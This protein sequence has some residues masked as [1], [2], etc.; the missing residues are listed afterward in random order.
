M[1]GVVAHILPVSIT[2]AVELNLR[3]KF[4]TL[5]ASQVVGHHPEFMRQMKMR[6]GHCGCTG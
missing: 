1:C 6:V 3:V 4:K 5:Q 2:V